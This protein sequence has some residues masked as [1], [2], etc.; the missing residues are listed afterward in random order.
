VLPRVVGQHVVKRGGVA[1]A[2]GGVDL[3]AA[4]WGTNLGVAVEREEAEAG[5]PALGPLEVAERGVPLAQSVANTERA[6][7]RTSRSSLVGSSSA[8]GS[9][10]VRT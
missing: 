5:G 1:A 4:A 10:Q 9:S 2:D 8:S 7:S 6:S 3:G